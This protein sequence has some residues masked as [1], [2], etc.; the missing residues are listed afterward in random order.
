MQKS[1]IIELRRGDPTSSSCVIIPK[2][3]KHDHLSLKGNDS[4][5]MQL[6]AVHVSKGGQVRFQNKKKSSSLSIS[7]PFN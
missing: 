1:P 7:M 5:S 2:V 4:K 3:A 6:K